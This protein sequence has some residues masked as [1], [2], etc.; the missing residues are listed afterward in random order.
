LGIKLFSLGGVQ[1]A[2]HPLVKFGTPFI[3]PKLS[4]RGSPKFYEHLGS[5][6]YGTLSNVKIFPLGSVWGAQHLLM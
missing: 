4:E 2:Q 1:G 5:V 6:K 3:S